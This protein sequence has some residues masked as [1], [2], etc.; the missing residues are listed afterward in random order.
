MAAGLLYYCFSFLLFLVWTMD[1]VV[2][3][4]EEI[5]DKQ[6]SIRM[7]THQEPGRLVRLL[8][9]NWIALPVCFLPVPGLLVWKTSWRLAYRRAS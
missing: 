9:S 5:R 6:R 4:Q 1:E 8:G 7:R 3:L 2:Q